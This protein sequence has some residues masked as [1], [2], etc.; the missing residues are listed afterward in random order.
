M[1]KLHGVRIGN[2]QMNRADETAEQLINN[3]EILV[4][5]GMLIKKQIKMVGNNL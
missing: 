1:F 5:F 2:A 4:V 3:S